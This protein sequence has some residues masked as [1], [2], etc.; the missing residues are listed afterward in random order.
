MYYKLLLL[1]FE[2]NFQGHRIEFKAWAARIMI[3]DPMNVHNDI[4]EIF[5]HLEQKGLINYSNVTN[6]TLLC[7]LIDRY[8]LLYYVN[9]FLKKEYKPLRKHLINRGNSPN[10]PKMNPRRQELSS[11]WMSLQEPLLS[12]LTQMMLKVYCHVP[13]FKFICVD[14]S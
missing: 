10:F 3:L 1:I 13:S 6:L 4:K 5:Y 11:N 8:D 7:K 14:I 9:C 2:D 12:L